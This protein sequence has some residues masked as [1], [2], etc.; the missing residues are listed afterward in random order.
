MLNHKFLYCKLLIVF[1]IAFAFFTTTSVY[2]TAVFQEGNVSSWS[3][4][5][6][7]FK[8]FESLSL[9][10]KN[11]AFASATSEQIKEFLVK[12]T[13]YK[14]SDGKSIDFIGFDSKKLKWG[15]G[16]L[17]FG[18]GE[19]AWI[20]FSQIKDSVTKISYDEKTKAFNYEFTGTNDKIT[21]SFDAGFVNREGEHVVQ[22]SS[23]F[24][25]TK[26]SVNLIGEYGKYEYKNG[27]YL[28]NDG[29]LFVNNKEGLAQFKIIPREEGKS[30]VFEV[31]DGF[32]KHSNSRVEVTKFGEASP[33]V[34][35][36]SGFDAISLYAGKLPT[37]GVGDNP[38]Q[39][40]DFSEGK[41]SITMDGKNI[42]SLAQV[43]S[44]DI[45]SV[46]ASGVQTYLGN[47]DAY[48]LFKDGEIHEYG[49]SIIA[50]YNINS[51]SNLNA[52]PEKAGEIAFTWQ[53]N[54]DTGEIE[55]Y[56]Y[57][58]KKPFEET[59]QQMIGGREGIGSRIA[60]RKYGSNPFE[61]MHG[62]VTYN[63]EYKADNFA[64]SEEER[65]AKIISDSNTKVEMMFSE[66]VIPVEAFVGK[67]TNQL[68]IGIIAGKNDADFK[69]LFESDPI[70]K[71]LTLPG[72]ILA[73]SFSSS[74]QWNG[75][76]NEYEMNRLLNYISG[77]FDTISSSVIQGGKWYINGQEVPGKSEVINA[78]GTSM[79]YGLFD[80]NLGRNL[81]LY[82]KYQDKI[83]DAQPFTDYLTPEESSTAIIS[84][85]RELSI[86]DAKAIGQQKIDVQVAKY[87]YYANKGILRPR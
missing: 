43:L 39:L 67:I 55:F 42:Y 71:A 78:F 8:A 16:N 7:S 3:E 60:A 72:I 36:S 79:T 45:K 14:N 2:I 54:S 24:S 53:K 56:S 48:L 74:A 70:K 26:T 13:Q 85:R 20:E 34:A 35:F 32:I 61:A 33:T 64:G 4:N 31:G 37:L 23:Y 5:Q 81:A 75:A 49:N 10:K 86:K 73:K 52:D 69:V 59:L 63:Q 25:S 82:T 50:K 38:Y 68:D 80:I 19:R 1:L 65:I 84:S 21:F 12:Y 62:S 17:L 87:T 58:P 40:I 11:T 41:K 29:A 28:I 77:N 44:D 27:Q 18:E 57:D 47:G 83:N 6:D 51:I 22:K 46:K 76:D 30:S 66:P 15:N 9:S